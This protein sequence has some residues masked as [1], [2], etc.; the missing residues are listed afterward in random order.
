MIGVDLDGTLAILNP[1]PKSLRK[2]F[3]T[4]DERRLK[5]RL[6]KQYR[7]E[8]ILNEA[9]KKGLDGQDYYIITGRRPK[10][11][12]LT[13]KWLSDNGLN[14]LGVFFFDEKEKTREEIIKYKARLIK[15]LNIT[16]YYEDDEKV[17]EGLRNLCPKTQILFPKLS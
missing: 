9:M 7:E 2:R 12:D 8:A 14:P 10:W 3:L 4:G 13:I 11:Q 15:N 16:T 17:V 1:M 5:I 6:Y